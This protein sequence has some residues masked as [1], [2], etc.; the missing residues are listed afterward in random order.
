MLNP[1]GHRQ[2]QDRPPDRPGARRTGAEEPARSRR[3]RKQA[4]EKRRERALLTRYPPRPSTT[5]SAEALAQIAAVTHAAKTRID[6]LPSS[7]SPSMKRWS[8]TRRTPPKPC[9]LASPGRGK[10]QQPGMV[11]RRFIA[12]QEAEIPRVNACFDDELVRLRQLW[13][14][15][16]ATTTPAAAPRAKGGCVSPGQLRAAVRLPVAGW[17]CP[18]W[19][20]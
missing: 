11:Q 5:R 7:A 12:E 4:E 15:A 3:T 13:A 8:S 1:S 18:C 17:P 10:H 14:Q 6:E 2:D 16:G 19:P 9:L 20:S